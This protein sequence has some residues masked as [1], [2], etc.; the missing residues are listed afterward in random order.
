MRPAEAHI[1]PPDIAQHRQL[2]RQAAAC[3]ARAKCASWAGWWASCQKS[4][5]SGASRD[6]DAPAS[7]PVGRRVSPRGRAH[8]SAAL[9]AS[10][11]LTRM[12]TWLSEKVSAAW[13]AARR[14]KCAA[15]SNTSTR[16]VKA[17]LQCCCDG[18]A[19]GKAEEHDRAHSARERHRRAQRQSGQ[20][21]APVAG[22]VS[23]V[24]E[25]LEL[26]RGVRR[27]QP[28][29]GEAVCARGH[30]EPV[31]SDKA[32]PEQVNPEK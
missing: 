9:R 8:Q 30:A 14:P 27:E 2:C 16:M 19:A 10:R 5:P 29:K 24:E 26:L 13:M 4:V 15:S 6:C 28:D 1:P 22:C 25:Q 32:Q 11:C 12:G 23:V 20:H 21:D 3:C 17:Q 18:L 7:A 31:D